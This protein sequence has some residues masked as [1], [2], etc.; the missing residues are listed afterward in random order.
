MNVPIEPQTFVTL[1]Y[2]NRTIERALDIALHAEQLEE[3]VALLEK[4]VR[5]LSAELAE[6]CQ[7]PQEREE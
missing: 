2:H 3:L 5:E 4:R 1:A 6:L 7:R